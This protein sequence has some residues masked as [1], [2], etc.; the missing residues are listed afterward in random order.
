[1]IMWNKIQ[2]ASGR[3]QAARDSHRVS[4]LTHLYC[5]R[6]QRIP[7]LR[8]NCAPLALRDNRPKMFV[9][10]LACHRNKK[11]DAGCGGGN[12]INQLEIPSRNITCCYTNTRLPHKCRLPARIRYFSQLCSSK[13]HRNKQFSKCL[14]VLTGL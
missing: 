10:S 5:S 12:M 2:N 6:L 7:G 9:F 4:Y 1:M 8:H 13:D 11:L 14:E 3:I